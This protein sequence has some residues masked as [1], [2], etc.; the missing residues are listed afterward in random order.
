MGTKIFTA[1][2]NGSGP[3]IIN[4]DDHPRGRLHPEG[5]FAA[6]DPEALGEAS[7]KDVVSRPATSRAGWPARGDDGSLYGLPSEFNGTAMAINAAL[8]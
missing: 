5:L 2:S 6:V 3:D 4:M 1:L 7:V 8:R